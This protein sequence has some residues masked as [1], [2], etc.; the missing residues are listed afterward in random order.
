MPCCSEEDGD[1]RFASRKKVCKDLLHAQFS[2]MITP[3]PKNGTGSKLELV[4]GIRYSEIAIPIGYMLILFSYILFAY[5]YQCLHVLLFIIHILVVC[6]CVAL[7]HSKKK[8]LNFEL[9]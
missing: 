7:Y 5:Q 2:S 8:T 3:N 9:H 4:L 6:I 1:L